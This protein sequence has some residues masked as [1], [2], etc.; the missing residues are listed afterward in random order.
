MI[1]TCFSFL[2]IQVALI[3]KTVFFFFFFPK[4][5]VLFAT[6]IEGRSVF[7]LVLFCLVLS[8]TLQVISL[9]CKAGSPWALSR[10]S[11]CV[12]FYICVFFICVLVGSAGYHLNNDNE[13][14]GL[15]WRLESILPLPDGDILRPGHVEGEWI[16]C[17]P[18]HCRKCPHTPTPPGQT[19]PCS[20]GGILSPGL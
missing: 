12:L 20:L 4:M 5:I 19:R 18:L 15:K 10:S 2:R 7:L 9:L 1:H 17:S 11:T 3:N 8:L 16:P 14:F 13:N 6:K